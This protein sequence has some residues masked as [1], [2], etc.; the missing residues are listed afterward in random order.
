VRV[1]DAK[2]QIDSCEIEHCHTSALGIFGS[3]DPEVSNNQINN[4]NQTPITMSMFSSPTFSGNQ[5]SNLGKNALGVAEEAFSLDAT[6]PVRDFAGVDS[7]TYFLYRPLKVNSGTTITIPA[8]LVFKYLNYIDCFDV[9]GGLIVNGTAGGPVVFTHEYDDDYGRPMD[10]NEDGSDT[11]PVIQSSSYCLDFAD[12]SDDASNINY[13][14]FRYKQAGINLRQASPTIDNCEF[15]YNN[16]GI[17]LDG[18]SNPAVTNNVFDELTYTPL[19]ISLVSYPSSNSGNQILGSTYRAMG[20]LSE[21]LV[22][23]VTLT[24]K[25][26]AGI[27]SI[28]YYFS[29]NYSIGTSV[30]LTIEPGVIMKF[31]PYARLTVKRGLLAEGGA[32]SDS[33]IVFT[34]IFDD[35]Y[36]GDTN[37]DTTETSPGSRDNWRGILFE[38]QSLDGLCRL[39]HCVIQ[40]AGWYS[41]EAAIETDAA[42]PRITR[43]VI[44]RNSNGVRATGA[45]QPFL[46]SC[47]IFNNTYYGVNNVNLS[48]IISAL[49]CWWGTNNGPT[50][51]DNPGGMGDLISDQV[52]WDPYRTVPQNPV[53]GDVSLNGIIQAFDAS[54]ILQHLIVPF[55]DV[56]QL[57]VA[58][59]SG[60]GTVQ[61]FDASLIL[62]YVSGIIQEFP[63]NAKKSA[64]LNARLWLGDA[65]VNAGDRFEIPIQFESNSSITALEITLDYDPELIQVR[66][67]QLSDNIAGYM[68]N[69]QI[70]QAEGEIKLVIAGVDKLPEYFTLGRLEGLVNPEYSQSNQTHIGISLFIANEDDL[71]AHSQ[72][73]EVSLNISTGTDFV[74]LV[75][76]LGRIY[77]NPFNTTVTIEYHVYLEDQPV[78]LDIFDASGRKIR[79][80]VN[81]TVEPGTYKVEWNP[82]SEGEEIMEGLYILKLRSG[83]QQWMK[84]I[85]YMK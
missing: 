60:N 46:D 82:A 1:F 14:I 53:M 20:V 62:Q 23:D 76:G 36:G 55:L 61:A 41:T 2:V 69:M 56:D 16:Y 63:V 65:S 59:V 11:K 31:A 40:Y 9:D 13:T 22:T 45:S 3:A 12:I 19:Q 15:K 35:F 58:D 18:V 81:K 38:N 44:T 25:L 67:L 64:G 73:A 5:A 78:H 54:Y 83:D 10:T 85:M 72:G 30:I 77:P 68:N 48:F 49:E 51:P 37:A 27:D 21:E 17:I 24:N 71:T 66:D 75:S 52:L 28:P 47:D 84:K 79:S 50:H 32:S 43:S 4:V 80:L 34:S 33:I 29:G 6:V 26:F 39:R 57:R 42:S 74:S 8:G 7:I 70:N